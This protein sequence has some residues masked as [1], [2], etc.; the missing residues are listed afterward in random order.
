MRSQVA[1]HQTSLTCQPQE[2]VS[3]SRFT[4]SFQ[5]VFASQEYRSLRRRVQAPLGGLAEAVCL[6]AVP[7]DRGGVVGTLDLRPPASA[8]GSHPKGVPKV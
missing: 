8:A 5:K 2:V 1:V 3:G 4:Q 7:S 6:V